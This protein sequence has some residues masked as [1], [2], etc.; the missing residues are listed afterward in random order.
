MGTLTIAKIRAMDAAHGGRSAQVTTGE[1]GTENIP[2]AADATQ[3]RR[4]R[5]RTGRT[6]PVLSVAQH[7]PALARPS[8]RR[9][10]SEDYQQPVSEVTGVQHFHSSACAQAVAQVSKPVPEPD[11]VLNGLPDSASE[12]S[13]ED[14]ALTVSPP[15][16]P[17]RRSGGEMPLAR[18]SPSPEGAAA[19]L[20]TEQ[21]LARA[22]DADHEA[23][24]E[25]SGVIPA[26]RTAVAAMK[27]IV[28][29]EDGAVGNGIGPDPSAVLPRLTP[30]ASALAS[31]TE[32]K[33]PVPPQPD[34]PAKAQAVAAFIWVHA[35]LLDPLIYH[36]H[37]TWVLLPWKQSGTNR[38][39][40]PVMLG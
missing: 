37:Q 20:A 36:S 38:E 16:T 17:K 27:P 39:L 34:V 32:S 28:A 22:G 7:S 6:H 1:G 12:K 18:A 5:E 40:E 15:S 35:A 23:A 8:L 9:P 19:L 3:V 13:S 11:S 10:A 4:L 25:G 33:A 14:S 2:A 26:A 31:L 21:L 30:E 29:A 24:A